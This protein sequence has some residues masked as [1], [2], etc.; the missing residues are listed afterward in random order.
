MAG[1]EN[2]LNDEYISPQFDPLHARIDNY[3]IY[4]LV[5]SDDLVQQTTD[6]HYSGINLSDDDLDSA[7]AAY[8][9]YTQTIPDVINY[10]PQSGSESIEIQ[11]DIARNCI[12][13]QSFSPSGLIPIDFAQIALTYPRKKRKTITYAYSPVSR[14]YSGS[15]GTPEFYT[16]HFIERQKADYRSLI[17]GNERDIRTVPQLKAVAANTRKVSISFYGR[18]DLETH[19]NILDTIDWVTLSFE[20]RKGQEYVIPRSRLPVLGT[21]VT[22]PE[23]KAELL[24]SPV[25]TGQY[26]IQL[27][28]QEPH[29][30]PLREVLRGMHAS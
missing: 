27:E 1:W 5:W 25:S 8:F 20:V 24:S 28:Q 19:P 15:G 11:T 10:P 23:T 30:Y 2:L 22:D 17:R 26:P 16:S 21:V 6:Y 18:N 13:F 4:S 12:A 14:P 3:Q 7:R 9:T 29:T